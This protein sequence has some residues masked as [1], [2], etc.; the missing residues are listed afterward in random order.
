MKVFRKRNYKF[1]IPLKIVSNRVRVTS[2]HIN[3]LETGCRKFTF[4]SKAYIEESKQLKN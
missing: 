1:K 4:F 3:P 2:N